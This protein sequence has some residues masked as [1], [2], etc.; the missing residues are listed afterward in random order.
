MKLED[1]LMIQFLKKF[2]ENPFLIKINGKEVLVGEG[3]PAFVVRFNK[4]LDIKELR[5]ST[6]LAL[7]E[8]YMRGDIEVEG[9][10]FQAL[11]QLLGQMGKFSLDKTALKKL[12]FTSNS[13]K[14][15]KDEVSSHYDIGNDFYRLWLDDTLSY[16][17]GYFKNPDDTLYD[18]QVNKVDYILE[19]LY[20]K[21]GMSLLDIGCGWGFLLIEAAKKYGINGVGITLSLEQHKKFSERIAE[22]G[23]EGQLTAELMDYR[24]LPKYGKTFD[25]IVSVGMVEHVGRDNYDLFLSCADKVLNPKG[26][27]LLHYISALEEHPGDPWI[28]KYIFPGGMIPSLR[29]MISLAASHRFYVIDVESLRRHYTK[30]LLCWDKGFREHLDEVRE[31]FDDEFIRMWDLY[32]CSCAA[33]FHNGIIDLSQILMTK[34]VNN[35]LPM[36]RWY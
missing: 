31:M 7:G 14:N 35:D 13:K 30:T 19:K 8:A 18:A 6:S 24:D 33:T 29:E 1:N 20:L 9:D 34:G 22:E 27:F 10:L 36:T 3:K 2:D 17:C 32:L 21:E 28:K 11:D 23:L 4:S 16:S 12:I 5:R 25:R 26:L 15:Q